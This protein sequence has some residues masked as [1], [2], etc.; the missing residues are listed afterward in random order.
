MKIQLKMYGDV[1]MI[2]ISSRGSNVSSAKIDG[3]LEV[4]EP[5]FKEV[6]LIIDDEVQLL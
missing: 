2:G 5:H 1:L 6:C 4:L 3:F